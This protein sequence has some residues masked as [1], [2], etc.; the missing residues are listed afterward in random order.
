MSAAARHE[1]SGL[2]R[3]QWHSAIPLV[4]SGATVPSSASGSVRKVG[5]RLR[6]TAE[7]ATTADGR[8]LWSARYDREMVDVFAMQDEIAHAVAQALTPQLLQPPTQPLVTSETDDLEAYQLYLQGRYHWFSRSAEGLRQAIR[9]FE[10]ALG[11]DHRYA[12]A[13]AGLAQTYAMVA[14]YGFAPPRPTLAKA[15]A[16][17][18]QALAVDPD[19]AEVQA[20]LGLVQMVRF[21]W[22]GSEAAFRHALELD[23]RD[24]QARG[25]L[26][27]LLASL[28]RTEEAIAE[29]AAAEARDPLAPYVH[30]LGATTSY[31]TRQFDRG[32]VSAQQALELDPGSVS[33]LFMLGANYH[34]AGRRAE[35]IEVY[36]RASR[37]TGR[38]AL[39]AGMLARQYGLAGRTGE[40]EIVLRELLDR[41]H[42]EYVDP[43]FLAYAYLGLGAH[44]QA[45]QWLDTAFKGHSS[46]L[47]TLRAGEAFDPLRSEPRFQDLLERMNFPPLV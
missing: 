16:A 33:G 28:G 23:P 34:G 43:V 9:F 46:L 35:A 3:G 38:A 25:W 12:R 11:K 26:A 42:R 45:M 41:T 4:A 36:E 2:V 6:V 13:H 10:R 17:G 5:D 30:V 18:Q 20:A 44:A 24:A 14:T 37:A 29:A 1:R 32:I 47:V 27:W 21:D 31:F 22:R 15:M 8:Q 40:A 7:L 19:R 39:F